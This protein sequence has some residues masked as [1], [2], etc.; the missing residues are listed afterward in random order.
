MQICLNCLNQY[1]GN[2]SCP[3]CGF[4]NWKYKP[5]DFC[6]ELGVI[7]NERY[8]IG[9][10]IGSGG[11]GITYRAV[12]LHTGQPVAIKEYYPNGMVSRNLDHRLVQLSVIG[13]EMA[14]AK[15]MHSFL[16]EARGLARFRGVD[17][18][19]QVYD[20]FEQNKTAYIVME[21]LRGRSLAQYVKNLGGTLDCNTAMN[22]LMDTIRALEVV[23]AAG[24]VHRDISP[25][26]LFVQ[27]NGKIKL[28]DFGAA[29]ESY[30]YEDKTL[31][32]VLK[33]NFA[34]PEQFQK[35]SRQGPWTDIYA[36]GATIY[37]MLTGNMP[38]ES[39]GRYMEDDLV[40]PSRFNTTVPGYFDEIILKMMALKIEDRYQNVDELKKAILKH[41]D[42]NTAANASVPVPAPQAYNGGRHQKA[43]ASQPSSGFSTQHSAGYSTQW[44]AGSQASIRPEEQK[45]T[46]GA[47]SAQIR[48]TK[49]ML[50]VILIGIATAVVLT[51]IMI[52]V[53][54]AGRTPAPETPSTEQVIDSGQTGGTDQPEADTTEAASMTEEVPSSEAV[55]ETEDTEDSTEITS[56]EYM[57]GAHIYESGP[58]Y[59]ADPEIF[60]CSVE[61]VIAHAKVTYYASDTTDNNIANIDKKPYNYLFLV[62][63]EN[64]VEAMVISADYYTEEDV[65]AAYNELER[66]YGKPE[67]ERPDYDGRYDRWLVDDSM[68]VVLHEDGETL[69]IFYTT[70]QYYNDATT[71]TDETD[72]SDETT[73]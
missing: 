55:T 34:P 29:R 37:K 67:Y 36:L 1:E 49:N 12:D 14:Y 33:P 58:I 42:V 32:I 60:N 11:F 30:G 6:L 27:N 9:T 35:K 13:K 56:L 68:Y 3:H 73:E 51:A 63:P 38:P 10:V 17:T 2:G 57:Y 19:V 54:S 45:P 7:L 8:K 18:I 50:P 71:D 48:Q 26:N 4:G 24:M 39:I 70:K 44:D 43:S 15:G 21:Y 23:H 28:I 20:Y 64:T 47:Q 65:T 22:F 59:I 16:E 41:V 40:P 52:V 62:E 72:G 53:V 66:L 46:T 61:E 25:D 5:N 31:S 69:Y